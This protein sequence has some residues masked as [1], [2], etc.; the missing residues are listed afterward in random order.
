MDLTKQGNTPIID[1]VRGDTNSRRVDFVL[2]AGFEPWCPPEESSVLI[3]YQKADGTG[4]AYDTL[5]DGSTAWEISGCT[6]T[7]LL[8]PQMLTAEGNVDVS[9]T[10]IHGTR[11]L[12]G[13]QVKL[14]V[15]GRVP[16]LEES[17]SYFSITGF[18]PQPETAAA[19]QYLEVAEV[20]ESGKITA[21]RAVE[22]PSGSS[23][24]YPSISVERFEDH[25]GSGV[26]IT[27][28]DADKITF[29]SVYDGQD[30]AAGKDGK[31]PEKGVD[32]F[33][34]TEKQEMVDAVLAALPD[35]E[36]EN[37]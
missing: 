26:R 31:T 18:I 16:T 29:H 32:Y 35:A 23:G 34:D 7:I 19:G 17:E 12:S 15:T 24:V 2:R 22:A 3:R 10:L 21:V 27:T 13:F 8:A 6:V 14:N 37:F 9:I 5:P 25:T 20:D 30:G 4:G 36:E 33:T 1:V 28:I 11:Q